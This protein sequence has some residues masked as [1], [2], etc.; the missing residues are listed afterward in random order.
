MSATIPRRT[1][2]G[3]ST[4]TMTSSSGVMKIVCWIPLTFLI[5]QQ[6]SGMGKF[7]N[8]NELSAMRNGV[9]LSAN[10]N[11]TTPLSNVMPL[12]PGPSQS[13]RPLPT[14]TTT[15]TTPTAHND[16]QINRHQ[17]DPKNDI[18]VPLEYLTGKSNPCDDQ[19]G[20]VYIDN[21]ISST[22]A[23]DI[24]YQ[25]PR[26][27]HQTS[28]SKCLT[29]MIA[30]LTNHWKFGKEWSYYFHDDA[31]MA[32]LFAL[33]WSNE[34]PHLN[35]VHKC[36]ATKGTLQA[37]LWRYLILYEYGGIYVDIDSSPNEFNDTTI[38][39]KDQGFFVVE[40]YH[41]LSQYFMAMAPKHPLMYYT[42]HSALLQILQVQDTG[43]IPAALTTGPHALHAGFIQYRKDVGIHV[44]FFAK[45]Q[46]CV[47]R[48]IFEGTHNT[49][50]R[51]EGVGEDEN[52]FV[53]R[54]KIRRSEK[55]KQYDVLGMKHF[56][57]DKEPTSQSC[58]S[59]IHH[60]REDSRRRLMQVQS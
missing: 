32:R 6:F 34:F 27:I 31:A 36:I 56:L 13:T 40:Q 5:I 14:T 28:K 60:A 41:L 46:K 29:P 1:N 12:L 51:V 52:Q 44:P 24:H 37:D 43:T 58:L 33:D 4:S 15:T 3:I 11:V 20:M 54:E 57:E 45:G 35:H 17:R 8:Y 23:S 48:H 9:R 26:Y 7:V 10:G 2:N 30:D 55:Q 22:P 49:T 42:I 38:T 18:K 39:P 53:I 50:I 21:Q 25:I 16:E 59:L 19:Q 47:W